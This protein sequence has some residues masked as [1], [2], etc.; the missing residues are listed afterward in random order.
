M[1]Q[2]LVLTTPACTIKWV[3]LYFLAMHMLSYC[4][5]WRAVSE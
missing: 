2:F 1:R 4:Y 3:L 5:R